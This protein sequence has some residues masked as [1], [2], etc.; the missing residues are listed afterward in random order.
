MNRELQER[1]C[2][3]SPFAPDDFFWGPSA[4]CIR[5]AILPLT[6]SPTS[7]TTAINSMQAQS[8]T[9]IHQ[10]TVWGY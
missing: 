6:S 2:K 8:G 5:T 4:D 10:G 3:Y 7:V 1:I 9:N